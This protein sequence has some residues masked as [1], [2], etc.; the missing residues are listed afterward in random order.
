MAVQDLTDRIVDLI[1]KILKEP[2]SPVTHITYGTYQSVNTMDS[3]LSI[4]KLSHV[5]GLTAGNTVM[6]VSDANTPLT[7]IGIVV[8]NI[9]LA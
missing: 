5:T 6:M 9:T 7:I 4:R 1:R 8:G 3:D 2:S